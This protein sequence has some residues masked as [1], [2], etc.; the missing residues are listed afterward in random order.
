MSSRLF[1]IVIGIFYFGI[2]LSA[3]A[4]PSKDPIIDLII[5]STKE[6]RLAHRMHRSGIR[7]FLGNEGV[8]RL[9]ATAKNLADKLDLCCEISSYWEVHFQKGNHYQ[10][11]GY[12]ITLDCSDAPTPGLALYF[13]ASDRFL[14][15][16]DFGH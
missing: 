4:S 8:D 15:S 5:H 1:A 7:H 13:D 14:G 11:A 9:R 12:E 6:E 2:Q 3:F 16:Y 10:L